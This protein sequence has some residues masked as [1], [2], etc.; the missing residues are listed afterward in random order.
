MKTAAT[1]AHGNG[2]AVSGSDSVCRKLPT[3][4]RCRS[5]RGF[6]VSGKSSGCSTA[7]IFGRIDNAGAGSTF[8]GRS[9]FGSGAATGAG[10]GTGTGTGTGIGTSE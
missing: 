3:G 5:G 2:D 10:V 8:A 4:A 9:I 7:G 6:D 1:A